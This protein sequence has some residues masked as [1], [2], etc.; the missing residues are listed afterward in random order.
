MGERVAFYHAASQELENARK[1]SKGLDKNDAIMEAIAFTMDVVEGKKKAATNENEFIYHEEVPERDTLQLVKGAP[2]VKGI[3]F[4]FNDIEVS[5]PDIFGRLV[6]MQAHEASSIYSEEKAQLLRKVTQ[7]CEEKD[8]SL[9]AYVQSLQLEAIEQAAQI[10]ING[11]KMTDLPQEVVDRAAQL[12]AN[13]DAITHLVQAMATLANLYHDV[14]SM[15]D[16]IQQYFNE[17]EHR[18]QEYQSAV[19]TRPPS[20][21]ATEL[22]REA[23]KY[24]E[25]HTKANESNQTLHRAMTLHVNNLKLLQL[26]LDE[27]R[28]HIP[29]LKM[30]DRKFLRLL[31]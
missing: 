10:I 21:V 22:K 4:N 29:T 2:L 31:K 6:P 7:Q 16:E 25:A 30:P 13:A 18:E 17:E 12:N 14:E 5:G 19:G 15:L 24:R 27:L 23:G 11:A 1:L 9:T 28:Q 20:M 3:P 8:Q 26:P